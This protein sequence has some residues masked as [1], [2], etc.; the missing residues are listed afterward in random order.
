MDLL[1]A[2]CPFSMSSVNGP[3]VVWIASWS[4]AQWHQRRGLAPSF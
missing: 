1:L 2:N 4:P 3:A